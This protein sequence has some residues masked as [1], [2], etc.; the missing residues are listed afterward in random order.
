[1]NWTK[2][3]KKGLIRYPGSKAKIA[4]RIL[5]HFPQQ[6]MSPLFQGNTIEYREPFFG[7][8][9]FGF[10]ALAGLNDKARIWL[11]DKD[12]AIACLWN[13]VLGSPKELVEEIMGFTPTTDSFYQF[14]K[15]DDLAFK[16]DTVRAALQKLALH[17]TSFSG[18]GAKAGGPLGG[19]KQSSEYNVECRWNA[20]R[21]AE[22]V[23]YLHRALKRFAS[24]KI[25]SGDFAKLID[26]APRHAFIYADPP[27]YER[28]NNS[29]STTC[30]TTITVASPTR[31]VDARRPGSSVTTTTSSF[32]TSTRGRRS[33][34][35]TSRI[36]S[37]PRMIAVA[38]TTR[39]S[40][41][42]VSPLTSKSSRSADPTTRPP[43]RGA[44]NRLE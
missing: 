35:S 28:A 15:E 20:D 37:R 18:L 29:T 42:R 38:R 44:S 25:S 32:A 3:A 13:A 8:G 16:I 14:K 12:P 11:N 43:A 41:S 9:G 36:R 1:M 40:S 10:Q 30:P 5:R 31:C 4:N 33:S 2:K 21:H 19:R 27:Y 22:Q 26:G 6:L 23:M 24:V 7:S 17:Q 34:R 39:S